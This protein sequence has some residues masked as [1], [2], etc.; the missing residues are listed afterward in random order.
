MNYRINP[1]GVDIREVAS[2]EMFKILLENDQLSQ[3]RK[4]NR[5]FYKFKEGDITFKPTFKYD[6]DSDEWDTR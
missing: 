2:S 3:Q 6:V 1:C 5:I 4:L